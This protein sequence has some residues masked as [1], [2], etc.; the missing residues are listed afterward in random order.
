MV[1]KDVAKLVPCDSHL[2][3]MQHV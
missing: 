3:A 1:L 2:W